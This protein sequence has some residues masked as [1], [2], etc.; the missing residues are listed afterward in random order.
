MDCGD[1]AVVGRSIQDG[2]EQALRLRDRLRSHA[3]PGHNPCT[4]RIQL[5]FYFMSVLDNAQI[6]SYFR[7]RWTH[8]L[9][10]PSFCP[11]LQAQELLSAFPGKSALEPAQPP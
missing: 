10:V 2:L 9:A 8:S 6:R 7:D 3:R 11:A 1:Q 5:G 4:P